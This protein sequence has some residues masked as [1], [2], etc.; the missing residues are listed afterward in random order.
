M[1]GETVTCDPN[2]AGVSV[3][4]DTAR[5]GR[6]SAP[7]RLPVTLGSVMHITPEAVTAL[8]PLNET[9]STTTSLSIT[10]MVRNAS[11]PL[12]A[13]CTAHRF[14]LCYEDNVCFTTRSKVHATTTSRVEK[15][16]GSNEAQH[17]LG[18]FTHVALRLHAHVH[19]CDT[20]ASHML[21]YRLTHMRHGHKRQVVT[22]LI[23][24]QTYCL[25]KTCP[26]LSVSPSVG[27]YLPLTS[28]LTFWSSL[29]ACALPACSCGL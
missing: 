10:S 4:R 3:P 5:D 27:L 28:S 18:C 6:E 19:V 8:T 16:D 21:E 29:P 13:S 11:T 24:L 15:R 23:P 2:C 1:R 25:S 7:G 26:C 20:P 12:S 9:S 14:L 22:N 17:V